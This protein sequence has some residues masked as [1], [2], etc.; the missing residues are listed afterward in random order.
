MSNYNFKAKNKKTGEIIEFLAID[1]YY[2]KHRYAYKPMSYET[3]KGLYTPEEFDMEFE[4]VEDTTISDI[5]DVPSSVVKKSLITETYDKDWRESLKELYL[6]Y[7]FQPDRTDVE[8]IF[9]QEHDRLVHLLN[10][11]KKTGSFKYDQTNK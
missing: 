11:Q 8:N 10:K 6:M 2:G 9:Q 4:P 7:D 3:S 1:N 5:W